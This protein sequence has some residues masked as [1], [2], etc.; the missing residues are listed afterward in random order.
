MHVLIILIIP[1]LMILD[2]YL[3]LWGALLRMCTFGKHIVIQSYELNPIFQR[4]IN[5]FKII[6]M[7]HLVFVLIVTTLFL[8]INHLN[9]LATSFGSALVGYFIITYATINARHC[10][11][12]FTFWYACKHPESM[13]GIVMLNDKMSITMSMNTLMLS[14]FPVASIAIA[15]FSSF[16]F[17]GTIGII[18][19]IA[20]HA[21]WRSKYTKELNA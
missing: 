9:G 14:L 6:N 18:L 17:G 2:Y 4:A 1:L 20:Q 10:A 7:Q 21:Y 13:S 16:A 11:N 3:T 8:I 15:T 5:N 19:L 12:I